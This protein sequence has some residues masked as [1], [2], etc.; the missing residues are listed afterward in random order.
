MSQFNPI[1]VDE[2]GYLVAQSDLGEKAAMFERAPILS[3]V[4]RLEEYALK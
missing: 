1:V 2:E 3:V 4:E